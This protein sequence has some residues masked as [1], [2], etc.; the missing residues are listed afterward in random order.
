LAQTV[1]GGVA[2]YVTNESNKEVNMEYFP[3]QHRLYPNAPI[4]NCSKDVNN[5]YF[6]Y[7]SCNIAREAAILGSCSFLLTLVN[8]VCIIIMAL[9]VLRIKEV[10]PLYQA[11]EA[12]QTFFHHDVKIARDCNRTIHEN[13]CI[14]R[15]N[16]VTE[17]RDTNVFSKSIVDHWKEFS[18]SSRDEHDQM[19]Y[20]IRT[21]STNYRAT[22]E[23]MNDLQMYAKDFELDVFAEKDRELLTAD[24][25][26]RVSCLVKSLLD[27]YEEDPPT[28]VD[29]CRYQPYGAQTSAQKEHL[30]FYEHLIELLPPKWYDLFNRERRQRLDIVQFGTRRSNSFS[31]PMGSFISPSRL[32]QSLS[33]R[34]QRSRLVR[35]SKKEP[36]AS[37]NHPSTHV[38]ERPIEYDDTL[39]EN[40]K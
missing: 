20:K 32:N 34:H 35:L 19:K 22:L 11:N 6:P 39:Q 30:T 27:M 16:S 40:M 26:E 14:P 4:V 17:K 9:I 37:D 29:F 28:F 7:Y 23:N 2:G 21:R 33:E 1:S 25:K 18:P 24:S 8:I 5:D 38:N 10:V 15:M 13:E 31:A 36:K 12:I 3:F